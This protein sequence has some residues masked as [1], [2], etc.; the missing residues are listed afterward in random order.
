MSEHALLSPSSAHRWINCPGS[1]ALESQFPSSTNKSAEYGTACHELAQW[2]LTD[3]EFRCEKYI[4]KVTENGHKVD[5]KMAELIQ[6]YVDHVVDYAEGHTLLV[7]Q[8]VDFSEDIAVENSFGTSDA[9]I[10]T[11]DASEIIVGDLKTGYHIVEAQENEQLMLYA[12]GALRK[13][14][15]L[16]DFKRVRLIIFQPSRDHLSEWDCSV[17]ELLEFV[18]KAKASAAKAIIYLKNGPEDRRL[19]MEPI[20]RVGDHCDWC[21]AKTTCPAFLNKAVETIGMDFDDL[22]E[23]ED[24][25]TLLPKNDPEA[26]AQK[27]DAVDMLESLCKA[28][29][30]EVERVLLEG[31]AVPNWKLVEGKKGNR[32]WVDEDEAEALLKAMRYKKEEMYDMKL[33]SPASAEKLVAKEKPRMWK[34]LKNLITQTDGQP[35]VAPEK[36]KRAAW[37]PKPI[38]DDF[39]NVNIEELA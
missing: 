16:G 11:E 18:K 13:F 1:V 29:R 35:S 26:L 25:K 12:V 22:T 37:S 14:E 38:S 30:A 33:V 21:K 19:G 17:E 15:M 36:D 7:E 34:K 4:G 23:V 9:V 2:A 3:G 27:M 28:I 20:L 32:K 24:V 31:I 8:K 5:K 39:N 10:I 6:V